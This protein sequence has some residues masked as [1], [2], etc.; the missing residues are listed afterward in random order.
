[1]GEAPATIATIRGTARIRVLAQVNVEGF[2]PGGLRLPWP[3][4]VKKDPILAKPGIGSVQDLLLQK[5]LPALGL[6]GG[7]R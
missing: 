1:M 2:G 3:R 4:G 6:A 7:K 5:A